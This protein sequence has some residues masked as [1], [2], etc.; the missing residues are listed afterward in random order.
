[1][2]LFE[3][4]HELYCVYLGRKNKEENDRKDEDLKKKKAAAKSDNSFWDVSEIEKLMLNDG[5]D[6]FEVLTREF[7]PIGEREEH[8]SQSE[9][10]KGEISYK[11]QWSE[12]VVFC[13]SCTVYW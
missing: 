10:N 9:K 2:C 1:M 3:E 13:V 4:D 12:F 8:V 7:E 6:H 5:V 11:Q